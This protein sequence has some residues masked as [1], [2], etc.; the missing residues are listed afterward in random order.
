VHA[1]KLL[2]D[3]SSVEFSAVK[4]GLLLKLPEAQQGEVDR[5]IALE[6]EPAK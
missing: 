5:V 1:A 6:L 2:R 3:E 4:G